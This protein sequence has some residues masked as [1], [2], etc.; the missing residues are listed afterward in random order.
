MDWCNGLV[1]DGFEE[2]VSR[3]LMVSSEIAT[4]DG[5]IESR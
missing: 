2:G 4:L 5:E 1:W 3:V